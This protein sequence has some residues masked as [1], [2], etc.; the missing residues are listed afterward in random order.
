MGSIVHRSVPT[1]LKWF[2]T[3]SHA[4]AMFQDRFKDVQVGSRWFSTPYILSP[5]F[6]TGRYAVMAVLGQ[7]CHHVE[8]CGLLSSPPCQLVRSAHCLAGL[9]HEWR[10]NPCNVDFIIKFH[11]PLPGF[12]DSQS[13]CRL[14][15]K[16]TPLC[17]A[18]Q[19]F[20]FINSSLPLSNH[21]HLLSI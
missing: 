17:L 15:L 16:S 10:H 5:N 1:N 4:H 8:G 13:Q 11:S 7:M 6:H 18:S 21:R 3:C 19:T 12:T 9:G 14:I 20:S 2:P